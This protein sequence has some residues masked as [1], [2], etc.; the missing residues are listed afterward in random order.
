MIRF[1][2]PSAAACLKTRVSCSTA[3]VTIN[4]SASEPLILDELRAHVLRRRSIV[5][6]RA[7]GDVVLLEHLAEIWAAPQTPVVVDHQEVGLP[8]L[9]LSDDLGEGDRFDRRRRR[10]AEDVGIAGGRDLAGR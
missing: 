8:D 10:N 4:V 3:L 6:T 9:S 5:S 1:F 7:D 2:K